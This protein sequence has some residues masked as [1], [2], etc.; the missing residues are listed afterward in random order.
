MP[1]FCAVFG[2]SNRHDREKDRSYYRL[3]KVI[4][5]QGGRTAELSKARRE[6][7]LSNIS[8]A[9]LKPSSYDNIRICSDH[10]ISK[11]L[12]CFHMCMLMYMT[13]MYVYVCIA[14]DHLTPKSVFGNFHS[15]IL[16]LDLL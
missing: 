2:C 3:P 9:D 6:K 10:F 5:H 13:I 15:Q 12:I 1:S 16:S 4:I 11:F 8:R 7:W 14:V